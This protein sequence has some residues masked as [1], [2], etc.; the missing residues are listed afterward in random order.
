MPKMD[1]QKKA[2]PKFCK[3]LILLVFSCYRIVTAFCRDFFSACVEPYYSLRCKK[4][5]KSACKELHKQIIAIVSECNN[6][7]K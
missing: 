4:Q 3:C 6:L 5:E 7:H 1:F 2:R